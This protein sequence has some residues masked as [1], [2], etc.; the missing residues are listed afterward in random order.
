MNVDN[1][2]IFCRDD[3]EVL[4]GINSECV[5][6]IYLDPPF[7][8]NK[9]FTAP[10]GSKAEGASFKDIFGKD[11]IKAEWLYELAAKH[12]PIAA[13]INAVRLGSSSRSN[14]C[15]LAYMAMRLIECHRVLK[16]SGSLYLHCDPTMSHHLKL[17]L[18]CIFSEGN[19]INEIIWHYGKW[20]N[21]SRNFQKNHDTILLYSKSSSY[22]FNSIYVA[23]QQDH[24][25][26][27]NTTKSGKQLLI[28]KPEE[29]AQTTIDRYKAKGYAV[30]TVD[31]PGVLE[32]DV[33][34]Y[35][36]D[37]SINFLNSQAKE[38]TGYPTQK[39]LAL[40]ERLI[41]TSSNKGD[42][43]LDPFCGCA[44]TCVAAEGLERQWIGIDVSEQAYMLVKSRLMA[45]DQYQ[46]EFGSEG[47]S[48]ANDDIKLRTDIPQRDDIY[49]AKLPP[50]NSAGNKNK[51]W[52]GQAGECA[53]CKTYFDKRHFEV[54]HIWPRAKGGNDHI[55]NLQLL[56]GSCNKIKGQR[57]MAEA[58]AV[59]NKRIADRGLTQVNRH[60]ELA[61]AADDM[62][63]E[64][65][66]LELKKVKE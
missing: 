63:I 55:S 19:F 58:I 17:L 34:S 41:E 18:D 1:R 38:R 22:T 3:L 24:A 15:Y 28:Y 9:D 62:M 61:D 13:L 4:K 40:L 60:R 54:D 44:T 12:R 50:Y 53:L 59:W 35:L 6:L 25:Y 26:Y 52:L 33:F 27:T 56:C 5:D 23:R 42:L 10:I 37:S 45:A 16:D 30:V 43:V 20:S 48:F 7:N 32:H 49:T 11:D 39:P 2:T 36:R 21:A 46:R 51:L 8:K 47:W 14:W 66:H 29:V 57:T 31:K 64:Q 65:M